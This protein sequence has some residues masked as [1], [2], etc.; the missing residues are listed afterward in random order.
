MTNLISLCAREQRLNILC[1]LRVSKS[2]HEITLYV[3]QFR[4]IWVFQDPRYPQHSIMIS[5][6]A[7][8][9]L[10]LECP[11]FDQCCPIQVIDGKSAQ[12]TFFNKGFVARAQALLTQRRELELRLAPGVPLPLLNL[13]R[14]RSCWE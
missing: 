4:D 6:L 2:G 12:W 13:P 3:K 10:V 1:F 9:T 7:A 5:S 8:S 11:Y 14:L